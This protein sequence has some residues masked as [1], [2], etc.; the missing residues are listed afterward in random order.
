MAN[1][2]LYVI[3]LTS[4]ITVTWAHHR[5]MEGYH[6][7]AVQSLFFTIT[8]RIYFTILQAYEYIEAL[9]TIVDAVYG[10]K[11]IKFYVKNAKVIISYKW[12]KKKKYFVQALLTFCTAKLRNLCNTNIVS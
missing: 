8:V 1:Y 2:D 6:S 5:L 9:F 4:G 7:Q 12:T 11:I 10:A 3:L